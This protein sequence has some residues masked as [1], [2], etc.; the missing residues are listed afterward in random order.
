MANLLDLCRILDQLLISLPH[1][2]VVVFDTHYRVLYLN[3]AS[4]ELLQC[5]VGCRLSQETSSDVHRSL[6]GILQAYRDDGVASDEMTFI[7]QRGMQQHFPVNVAA[8]YSN[9]RHHLGYGLVATD[10]RVCRRPD[11]AAFLENV[12]E[13]LTDPLMVA[14]V[15]GSV[16]FL[17]S[18]AQQFADESVNHSQSIALGSS[19]ETIYGHGNNLWPHMETVLENGGAVCVTHEFGDEGERQ[20]YDFTFSPLRDGA[21][22]IEG[23]IKTA[24]D[25]TDRTVVEARLGEQEERVQQLL[26]YDELTNLPSRLLFTDR[27]NSAIARGKLR[28]RQ[29]A[30]LCLDLDNFK[31]INDSLGHDIGDQ[32]LCQ[33]AKR[34]LGSV[35]IGDTVARLSGDDFFI[36]LESPRDIEHVYVI[37]ENLLSAVGVKMVVDDYEF[38]ITASLGISMYPNDGYQV[39]ELMRCAD[40]AMYKAKKRGGSD[41]QFFNSEMDGRDRDHLTLEI[42]LRR[43]MEKE[44]L[45]VY[46]QPQIDLCS[47]RLIGVEALLRWHHPDRGMVPPVE[48]IPIAEETGLINEIGVWVMQEACSQNKQWQDDGFVPICMAVNISP[49]QFRRVNLVAQVEQ[50]LAATNLDARYLELEITE[51]IIMD[52]VE[53]AIE[54]MQRLKEMGVKLS[55]DDFGT[56][57][58][59]LSY[60][61]RFQISKLKIDRSF[62]DVIVDEHSAAQVALSIINLAQNLGLHVIAEGIETAEQLDCLREMGCGEGQGYLFGRPVNAAQMKVILQNENSTVPLPVCCEMPE[63]NSDIRS[64]EEQG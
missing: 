63:Q 7:D 24:R 45:E 18:A 58:S 22:N 29:V 59:S 34:L 11:R 57:Y 27:L 47:G 32:V 43:A 10:C 8:L 54:T 39:P 40:S 2:A 48:F 61:R 52:D 12:I 5:Y 28:Q 23:V 51:G 3:P 55:I 4:K 35:N 33:V 60:L 25:I 64:Q 42:A 17:N 38:Y 14:G 1:F 46:Y 19:L 26:N 31:K 50:V 9:D 20:V 13:S 36:V 21:G 53:S 62:V 44:E 41:F 16:R 37:A 30:V 49:R 6:Y 56:G 15:D